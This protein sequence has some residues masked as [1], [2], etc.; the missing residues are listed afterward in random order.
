V[1]RNVTVKALVVNIDL[2]PTIID[3]AGGQIPN[4]MDGKSFLREMARDQH[5]YVQNVRRHVTAICS[6]CYF[7][8]KR[9]RE[10]FLV[11]YHGEGSIKSND[12]E[13]FP[14]IDPI[15]MSECSVQFGCKCQ[16][17]FELQVLND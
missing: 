14:I 6:I 5:N 16:V 15:E 3:M 8:Q 12:E 17:L 9:S 1:P 4:D 7:L 10:S 11:S 13:C 2:A